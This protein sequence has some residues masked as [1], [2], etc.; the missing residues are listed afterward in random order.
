MYSKTRIIERLFKKACS[1]NR[2]G[3]SKR[4]SSNKSQNSLLHKKLVIG[5]RRCCH[6]IWCYRISANERKRKRPVPISWPSK[7]YGTF[8]GTSHTHRI[9]VL[10]KATDRIMADVRIRDH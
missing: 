2:M 9:L 3:I 7:E 6:K 10:Q 4:S 1:V 5:G 8:L